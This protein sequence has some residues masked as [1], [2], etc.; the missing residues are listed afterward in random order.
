M[1]RSKALLSIGSNGPSF[2][3][4]IATT[5]LDGGVSD[6]LV[7]GRPEDAALRAEIEQLD[8]RVRFVENPNAEDGQLS[9]VVAAIN[10]VDHPGTRAVVIMPVDVPLVRAA[11]VASVIEAFVRTHAVIVRA[12]SGGRHGHPV[13]FA[14][15]LFGELRRA[16]PSVGAKSVLRAH[17]AEIVNVEVPDPGVL[18]DVDSPDDY[19]RL[20]GRPL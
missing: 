3:R 2:V 17:Q 20:F 18:S 19:E 12:A 9:S 4:Q 5:L 11:S 8:A 6:V 16:D 15:A 10:V 13:L 1:G 14:H 7:V